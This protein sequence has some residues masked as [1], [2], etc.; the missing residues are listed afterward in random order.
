MEEQ[1]AAWLSAFKIG[2]PIALVVISVV[3]SSLWRLIRKILRQVKFTNSRV[4]SMDYALEKTLKNGY[5]DCRDEK[6]NAIIKEDSFIN[7]MGNPL[8][9]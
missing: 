6:L 1:N 7:K 8:K 5:K 3:L 4:I 9:V 2:T